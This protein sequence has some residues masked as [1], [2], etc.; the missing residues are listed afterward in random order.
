[1][2]N[3]ALRRL[4]VQVV[5][6]VMDA[7]D[8]LK[9]FLAR[10]LGKFLK[11]MRAEPRTFVWL[12]DRGRLPIL[13]QQV[14][15]AIDAFTSLVDT[16]V[17]NARSAAARLGS[18]ASTLLPVSSRLP[19]LGTMIAQKIASIFMLAVNGIHQTVEASLETLIDEPRWRALL[20]ARTEM[21]TAYRESLLQSFSDAGAMGW[22]WVT[23]EDE[24]VCPF[25]TDMDGT[26]HSFAERFNTHPNCRCEAEPL[27]ATIPV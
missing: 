15:N 9:S 21:Y 19:G 26:E 2:M 6:V 8:K 12:Y 23:A 4:E 17:Q 16:T 3:I 18:Q 11:D 7:F 24:R 10:L 25:C 22:I 27:Y 5:H 1:M 20:L 13:K 14:T